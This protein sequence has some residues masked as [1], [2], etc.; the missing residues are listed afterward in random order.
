M[1]HGA[2]RWLA[3]RGSRRNEQVIGMR[4]LRPGIHCRV[5]HLE[6]ITQLL[7]I[8]KRGEP[9]SG[10]SSWCRSNWQANSCSV[11][12]TS[13]R[14]TVRHPV[15]TK[16]TS[17]DWK[18][19]SG[20]AAAARKPGPARSRSSTGDPVLTSGALAVRS[21][22]ECSI[23]AAVTTCPVSGRLPRTARPAIRAVNDARDRAGSTHQLPVAGRGGPLGLT[24]VAGVILVT[25]ASFASRASLLTAHGQV[26]APARN[27]LLEPIVY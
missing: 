14:P 9:P 25:S 10:V 11:P 7:T 24:L 23:G 26:P 5:T 21:A 1:D 17:S 6:S 3:S 20:K 4:R 18:V 16:A 27:V 2:A 12:L 19:H 13:R 15:G 8:Q 22:V